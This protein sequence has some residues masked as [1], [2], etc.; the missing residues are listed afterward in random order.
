M[1][2]QTLPRLTATA[3]AAL[4]YLLLL[5]SAG[6]AAEQP[7]PALSEL[8]TQTA[9]VNDVALAYRVT[10][11]GEPLLLIMGYGGTMDV[12]DPAM[13]A[14]LAKS[15]MVI[16]FDNRG[17]GYSTSSDAPFSMELFASDAAGLLDAL[18]I[19]SAN[20]LGWS[21]GSIIAQEMALRHPEK[22]RKLILY[23]AACDNGQV[24][25]AIESMGKMGKDEFIKRLFPADWV[26]KHPDVFASLPSPTM[27]A[28]PEVIAKQRQAIE[29]WQGTKDRLPGLVNETLLLFGQD[30]DITP[31]S[32]A[33]VM[34]G[35]IKA[36]WLARF[37][38]AGHWLM[39]QAPLETARLVAFF[40]G[41]RENL[42][43]P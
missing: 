20:I 42:L 34:A 22:T 25:Q 1:K 30:D 38:G 24:M 5:F 27:P 7:A 11:H 8:E 41:T 33:T 26:E 4:A 15:N 10:G 17:V 2:T 28:T 23:G 9:M 18:S 13:V 6:M 29:A 35:L 40:L 36:S 32:G 3:C 43:A 31:V 39:Y 21:M 37:E 19:E 12:W 14:E 16:M